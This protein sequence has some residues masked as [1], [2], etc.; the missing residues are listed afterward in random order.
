MDG[1]LVR[2]AKKSA[3]DHRLPHEILSAEEVSRRFPAFN[4]VRGTVAVWEPRAGILFP[5]LAVQTHLELALRAGATLQFDDPVLK[6]EPDGAGVCVFTAKERY[7][8]RRLFLSAGPWLGSLIPELKIPLRIERQVLCWFE[9]ISQPEFLRPEKCPIFIWEHA[10]ARFFY[11]FPDL[12]DGFKAAIHH[13]GE[14]TQPDSVRR[15]VGPRDT[16]AVRALLARYLPSSAG[17]LSS[18]VVCMYTNSPDAHFILG[19]HPALRQVLI[20]SP[21]SGHGFKFAPVIAEMALLLLEDRAPPFDLSLF[22]PD[23]FIT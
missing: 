17:R 14:G 10:P 4:P 20:A 11:G 3:E 23:R 19:P 12:G 22:N 13:E 6:W 15:E 18:A 1:V 7:R 5:E 9:P 16:E 21:C 8:A 2:G